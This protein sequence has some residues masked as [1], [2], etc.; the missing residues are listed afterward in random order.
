MPF[1]VKSTVT[2]T[3]LAHGLAK[4]C[5]LLWAVTI[6]DLKGLPSPC[7]CCKWCRVSIRRNRALTNQ[8]TCA[9]RKA[10]FLGCR[11][12]SRPAN[13]PAF[14]PVCNRAG[15]SLLHASSQVSHAKAHTRPVCPFTEGRLILDTNCTTGAFSGYPGP[16]SMCSE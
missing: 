5:C 1:I 4:R 9:T 14:P 6:C 10:P 15:S 7:A 12:A 3:T 13:M 8:P 16:H 2:T 11:L